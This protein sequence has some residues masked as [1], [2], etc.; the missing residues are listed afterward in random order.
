MINP[1]QTI[2]S[3]KLDLSRVDKTWTLFLDRDG[4]IN[5]EKTDYVYNYNE[6]VFY[7]G[8]LDA[9]KKFRFLFGHIIVITNQRGVGRKL[10]TEADLQLIHE[11]MQ[12][13][14][15]SAGGKLDAIYYCTSVDNADPNRKPNPGMAIQAFK[16]HEGINPDRTIMVGNN[17][18]D[19][20]FGKNAGIHTILL[21][22]TGTKVRLPHPLVEAQFDTLYDFALALPDLR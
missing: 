9:F 19:M 10:M 2:P 12:T 15:R 8:V 14:I 16:D 4:V 13:D 21:T 7:E 18:S 20:E 11:S 22:T 5:H 17:L 1:R 3:S 6:F